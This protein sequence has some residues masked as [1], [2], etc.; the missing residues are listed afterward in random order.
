MLRVHTHDH[1]KAMNNSVGAD[2]EKTKAAGDSGLQSVDQKAA[3]PILVSAGL[4]AS[5]LVHPSVVKRAQSMAK[6]VMEVGMRWASY[7]REGHLTGPLATLPPLTIQS[8]Y[9]YGPTTVVKLDSMYTRLLQTVKASSLATFVGKD[10]AKLRAIV[11]RADDDPSAIFGILRHNMST[12]C[13]IIMDRFHVW[14]ETLIDTVLD[15]LTSGPSHSQCTHLFITAHSHSFSDMNT[16]GLMFEDLVDTARRFKT[17][18]GLSTTEDDSGN[19]WQTSDSRFLKS[20]AP[21]DVSSQLYTTA[22][23][24]DQLALNQA[25]VKEEYTFMS[26]IS[27]FAAVTPPASVA[28]PSINLVGT[29]NKGN[30]IHQ[31][32]VAA[33]IPRPSILILFALKRTEADIK[34]FLAEDSGAWGLNAVTMVNYETLSRYPSQTAGDRACVMLFDL[35]YSG[36]GHA[37]FLHVNA[38]FERCKGE[39]LV[40]RASDLRNTHA[41]DK[42]TAATARTTANAAR[43]AFSAIKKMFMV[44]DSKTDRLATRNQRLSLLKKELERYFGNAKLMS[45]FK[46]THD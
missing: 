9:L 32:M 35:E 38:A 7:C 29:N 5:V 10:P 4:G 39:V 30:A 22:Q 12:L 15:V 43:S 27:K 23:R 17:L 37:T 45:L 1:L 41:P 8:A 24:D 46:T 16:S 14:S 42:V 26:A 44:S 36:A 34:K 19:F 33:S 13:M 18:V 20:I 21:G 28:I 40:F 25:I 6:L 11:I 3:R 31:E 2:A